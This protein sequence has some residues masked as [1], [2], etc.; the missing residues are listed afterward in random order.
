MRPLTDNLPKPLIEVCGKP[1]LWHI[2]DALPPII[3]EVIIVVG[4]K[5]EMIREQGGDT[6]LG[7]R[8]RYVTQ[9]N[10]KGGTAD[11]LATARHLLKGRFLVMNGDD[12]HGTEALTEVTEQPSGMLAAVSAT[13][14]KFGVLE[15]N[16]DGTLSA[17]V[18]KPENP[19]SNL[20][21]TGCYVVTEEIFAI[22]VALS[23]QGEYY[24]TDA[25]TEYAS[26]H[27]FFVVKQDSWLP[28]GYPEDIPKA[29]AI[30]CPKG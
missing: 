8:M 28:I 29:E 17:I 3:D 12:I 6:F 5:A 23:A 7:R 20:V 4:Y 15:L 14:E 9:E 26:R 22:E 18:E 25:I 21:N 16:E 19:P 10:P 2:I 24:L 11:A 1:I 27:P 13:P 30:L